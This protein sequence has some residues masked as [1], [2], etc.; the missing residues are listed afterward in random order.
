M[1]EASSRSEMWEATQHMLT[2]APR[3]EH[4]TQSRAQHQSKH[5]EYSP[6]ALRVPTGPIFPRRT[7]GVTANATVTPRHVRL[8]SKKL[9]E[10]RHY[11]SHG[12]LT[13]TT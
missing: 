5:A 10:T 13:P 12:K 7:V 3:R 9:S 2:T 8:H 11:R 1:L 4:S 6:S